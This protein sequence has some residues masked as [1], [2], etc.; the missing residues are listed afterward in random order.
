M[1][2]SLGD[3]SLPLISHSFFYFNLLDLVQPNLMYLFGNLV[4]G[5]LLVAPFKTLTILSNMF[6]RRVALEYLINV[7]S[8]KCKQI[9]MFYQDQ[10]KFC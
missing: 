5:E 1:S 3:N 10:K 8:R 6:G 7:I 4:P 2:H 9:H